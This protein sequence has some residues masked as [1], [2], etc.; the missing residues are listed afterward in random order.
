LALSQKIGL[1]LLLFPKLV[2]GQPLFTDVTDEAGINH[3]FQVFGGTFGGGAA[4]LDYNL[5]G[6]EDVFITGGNGNNHLYKNNGDGTFE[7]VSEAAGLN[8]LS[9]VVTQGVVSADINKDGY[10]DLFVTTIALVTEGEFKETTDFLLVNNGDGTFSD[11]SEEYGFIKATFSTGAAFGDVNRDGYPDLYVSVFFKDFEG[12][13]DQYNGA[14]LNNTN[15]PARDLLYINENGQKFIESSAIYGMDH[16]GLGFQGVWSDVDND[17]DPD[18]LIANDF[19]FRGHPNYLYRNEYPERRLTN[20]SKEMKFAFG[21]S[22]M[23]IG[24]GDY[25]QDGWMDYLVTN[26]QKS[27]FF[28]NQG[29]EKVFKENTDSLGTGFSRIFTNSGKG[30]PPI[31]WGVNFFDVD[32]DMDL[33]LYISNGCLNPLITP[34]PNLFLMN[35]GGTFIETGYITNT[36]DHSIG[37]GSVVF[38]YDNDGDLDLLVVNQVPNKD[39]DVGIDFLGTRLF[40]NENSTNNWLKVKLE[41]KLSETN[42]IGSRIE[43]YVDSRVLIREI[44]GGSSHE[45]QNSTIAHFGL[46]A[47]RKVDSIVVKW[48]G[49]KAQTIYDIEANQTLR[50]SDD[51][52]IEAKQPWWGWYR[53]NG[54]G[55]LNNLFGI[56]TVVALIL[57]V[58]GTVCYRLY[59]K[60][61]LTVGSKIISDV[62][63]ILE[64]KFK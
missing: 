21:M 13:L 8:V 23:G 59:K 20:V 56:T 39:E 54:T 10:P 35:K 28:V 33:D 37:R 9:G 32:L 47:F 2:F 53:A 48:S 26:I 29:S 6:F 17:G 24:V 11:K 55:L 52:I 19:G 31:S 4:V 16:I 58:V 18:L 15:G 51:L 60:N 38:D 1:I 3:V 36:N 50:L 25:N 22:G 42:G 12:S 45:S 7:N 64:H 61:L 49:A 40:R 43:V 5:D 27:R 57:L 46:A 34:N 30:V 63:T 14:M 62:I 44:D 41:G